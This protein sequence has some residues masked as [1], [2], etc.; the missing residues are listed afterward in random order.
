MLRWA[1]GGF[2]AIDTIL[3]AQHPEGGFG[4]G[5]HQAAHLL[6]TYASVCA[7]AIVGRPGPGG[8]WDQIDRYVR[9]YESRC[10]WLM[11]DPGQSCIPFSCLSSSLMV[12]SASL[13]TLRWISGLTFCL[14]L[15]QHPH[16][17]F[18]TSG[19]YCLLAVA[20]LLN[21]LTST[22]VRGVPGFVR[23]CQ[24]Y[25]GGFASASQ[26]Y[27]TTDMEVLSNPRPPLGEAHGGYTSCALNS[28][29][30][31][32]PFVQGTDEPQIDV[33]NALHWLAKM[34]CM[35]VPFVRFLECAT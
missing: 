34:Q 26:P 9:I 22:L 1:T 12:L 28:W 14:V 23:S 29:M 25:E 18:S 24:T 31:L 4:G 11:R 33:K 15:L 6:P 7:L 16:P 19:T 35:L 8:G 5:P 30:L 20:T 21:I 10:T 32:Q 13:K 2:R 17:F 27:Y 3:A